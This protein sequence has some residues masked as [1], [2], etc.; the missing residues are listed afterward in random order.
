MSHTDRMSGAS[1]LCWPAPDML[2]CWFVQVLQAEY[3]RRLA[4]EKAQHDILCEPVHQRNTARRMAAA[5]REE[6]RRQI[7]Q[8]NDQ[9]VAAAEQLHQQRLYEAS[10]CHGCN[11]L[12]P[13]SRVLVVGFRTTS[14]YICRTCDMPCTGSCSSRIKT[15]KQLAKGC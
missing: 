14:L 4:I 11:T 6:E 12:T 1:K 2:H 13:P 9:L 10:C 8:A 5:V 3:N 15:R 7:Q